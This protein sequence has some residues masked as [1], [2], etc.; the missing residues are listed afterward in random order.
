MSMH[1]VAA[2]NLNAEINAIIALSVIDRMGAIRRLLDLMAGLDFENLQRLL[3][4][5][6][7][8]LKAVGVL[9]ASNKAAFEASLTQAA[10]SLDPAK[11]EAL[12]AAVLAVINLIL[13][14]LDKPQLPTTGT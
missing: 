6:I 3:L 2:A 7:D 9:D 10:A 12:M 1:S 13:S 4:L 11:F 8:G 5:C 14:L